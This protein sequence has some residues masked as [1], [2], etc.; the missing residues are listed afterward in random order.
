MQQFTDEL[1]ITYSATC[2]E[3]VE[4]FNQIL[5]LYLASSN[6]VLP[7]LDELK[8]AETEMPMIHCL[9]VYLLKQASDPRLS[10]TM[11]LAIR[12]LESSSGNF[13]E[14]EQKHYEAVK[15][16]TK[17][18]VQMTIDLIE[19]LLNVYPRDI[20]ALRVNHHLHFYSGNALN[21][22]DSVA[23]SISSWQPG[24]RF[25]GYLMGMYSFGLEEAAD[26]KRAEQAGRTAV[27]LN[28]SDL[29]AG[30]AV[31]HVM[32]MQRRFDEGINWIRSLIP[33]WKNTNN[34]IYHLYWHEGLFHIGFGDY[35][36]A[37]NIYDTHL[38]PPLSDDFYLDICNAA[39][40][41]WRLEMLHVNVGDRWQELE[42]YSE[43][44]ISDDELVFC[45]LHYLLAPA[46]LQNQLLTRQA[47][48]H[49]KKWGETDTTQGAVAKQI[50]LPL[51]RAIIH[52]GRK[53]F[54]L[55]ARIIKSIQQDI[56]QIGGSHAQRHLFD[57][58]Q[59][60]ARQQ[61]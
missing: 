7:K 17:N 42:N 53:E 35:E 13:N 9:Q 29:W 26:Y 54:S 55:A 59:D 49:F 57:K 3:S 44:R 22:R 11:D 51:A 58:M 39:S 43:Q 41:L 23:R 16:W 10:K 60:Y 2:V 46:R 5:E 15:A 40:L 52:L 61:T 20:L 18:Q 30:H 36:A 33:G 45:T 38:R 19:E 48:E 47:L 31:T 8:I 50:G 6:K 12:K 56:F 28:P 14:R 4:S 21:L 27:G 32:H 34:F 37:L 24:E 25:Y 1:G